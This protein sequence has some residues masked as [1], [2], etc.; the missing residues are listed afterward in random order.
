MCNVQCNAMCN[1]LGRGTS[2]P[3][4]A[5]YLHPSLH[6]Q[7]CITLC[8][9]AMHLELSTMALALELHVQSFMPSASAALL[10]FKMR[11]IG[12]MHGALTAT[13]LMQYVASRV[14]LALP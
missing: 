1:G 2:Q 3:S 10:K 4:D 14:F 8:I 13:N 12:A 11:Q 9:I 5:L 7:Q 6:D